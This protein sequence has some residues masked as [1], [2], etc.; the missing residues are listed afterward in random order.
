MPN[1]ATSVIVGAVIALMPASSPESATSLRLTLDHPERGT[2]RSVTLR[3]DPPGGSH[4]EAARACSE[5]S[6]S[7]GGFAH[8]PDGRMCTA[9]HSPVVARAA[10][11]W[12]GE[13]VRFRV[14]Y[15][16]DCVMRSH[17][18]SVFAF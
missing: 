1:L 17:T 6:G 14:E 7:G 2:S 12:R 4:P 8:G 3:C 13:P 10:G 9:V 16:N 11:R 18:G 5:L 15:G